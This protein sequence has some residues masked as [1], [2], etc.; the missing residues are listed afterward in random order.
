[1]NGSCHWHVGARYSHNYKHDSSTSRWLHPF[2]CHR[3]TFCIALSECTQRS[4]DLHVLLYTV[5]LEKVIALDPTCALAFCAALCNRWERN[6]I[7]VSFKQRKIYN[8]TH[9]VHQWLQIEHTHKLL[10]LDFIFS[11]T[12]LFT[13]LR[14]NHLPFGRRKIQ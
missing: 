6:D 10:S 12:T 4:S 14:E 9:H 8:Y 1:M 7:V 13:G 11:D 3:Q 2:C 5:I